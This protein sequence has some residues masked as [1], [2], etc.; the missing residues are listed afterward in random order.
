MI[1]TAEGSTKELGVVTKISAAHFLYQITLAD[2]SRVYMRLLDINYHR[3]N[4]FAV[5]VNAERFLQ[6]WRNADYKAHREIAH[7]NPE[8]WQ[9]DYKFNE[10]KDGFSKGIVNPV[11]LADVSCYLD[12]R[13]SLLGGTKTQ[14]C[15]GFTNGIT[16]TIYL[17]TYGA[18]SFPVMCRGEDEA[19][20]MHTHAGVHNCMPKSLEQLIPQDISGTSYLLNNGFID[21]HTHEVDRF[22]L[23]RNKWGG[24]SWWKPDM[25]SSLARCPYE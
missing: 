25:E 24:E 22:K 23:V 19:F 15:V 12:T 4:Q 3:D 9:R 1:N 11:P 13:K 14:W 16:R 7:G 5:I 21:L 2:Q 20:N 17:L 8:S 18:K 10:A 6:L